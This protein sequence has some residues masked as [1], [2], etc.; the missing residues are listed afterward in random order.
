MA[1]G[2]AVRGTTCG[3]IDCAEVSYSVSVT[4]TAK[5]TKYST[6][7]LPASG[8]SATAASATTRTARATLAP[9]I[10]S[11]RSRRSASAPAGSAKSSHG[12]VRANV[13][14]ATSAGESVYRTATSG[15]ATLSTPSARFDT[16]DAAHRR[17]NGAPSGA[18]A[19]RRR[20]GREAMSPSMAQ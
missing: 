5:A 9:T 20:P 7:M 2:S 17:R 14:P 4:P 15:S 18:A 19:G 12:S 13:S 6:A 10:A 1:R 11:R 16:V 3:R 8:T